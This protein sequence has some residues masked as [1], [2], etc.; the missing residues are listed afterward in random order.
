MLRSFFFSM[1]ILF[2]L[3]ISAHADEDEA[4]LI[5]EVGLIVSFYKNCWTQLPISHV[6]KVWREVLH[7]EHLTSSQFKAYPLKLSEFKCIL[8]SFVLASF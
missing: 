7:T 4:T 2:K 1:S 3:G 5:C 6:R 8:V